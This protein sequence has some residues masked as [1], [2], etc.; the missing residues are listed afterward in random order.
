MLKILKKTKH[1]TVE[2][3]KAMQIQRSTLMIQP[4]DLKTCHIA[5]SQKKKHRQRD[6]K[7]KSVSLVSPG[8]GGLAPPSSR[9]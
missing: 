4:A 5:L 1:R 6:K 7:K 2:E 8:G 9:C 3:V